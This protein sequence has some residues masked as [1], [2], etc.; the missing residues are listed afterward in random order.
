MAKTSCPNGHGL[1][2]GDD[3]LVWVFRTKFFYKYT[4]ENPRFLL[5]LETGEIYDCVD[6]DPE[7][8]EYYCW[9]CDECKALVFFVDKYRYEYLRMADLPET[10]LDDV[11]EWEEYIALHNSEFD[12]FVDFYEGRTPVWAIENYPFQYKYRVS[13]DQKTILAFNQ[14]GNIQFGYQQSKIIDLKEAYNRINKQ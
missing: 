2:D 1:W 9:Y 13:P 7:E 14:A 3:T 10:T 6:S 5:G 12:R 4:E 11:K 8:K